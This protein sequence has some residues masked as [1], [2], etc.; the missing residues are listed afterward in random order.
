MARN[1][2]NYKLFVIA[3]YKGTVMHK[4]KEYFVFKLVS[5]GSEIWL[6]RNEYNNRR[7]AE[8]DPVEGDEFK[9]AVEAVAYNGSAFLG[10]SIVDGIRLTP[11][12]DGIPF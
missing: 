6:R 4:D 1:D 12:P 10:Y 9:I 7:V 5:G 2:V 8:A 3:A 11:E